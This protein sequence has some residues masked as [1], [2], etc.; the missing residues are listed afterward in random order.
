MRSWQVETLPATLTA[1]EGD[2]APIVKQQ[3][4]VTQLTGEL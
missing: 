4:P 1:P 3:L 2:H